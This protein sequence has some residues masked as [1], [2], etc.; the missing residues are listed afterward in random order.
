MATLTRDTEAGHELPS[1]CW[2]FQVD[3]FKK[4]DEKT[5]HNDDEA[6]KR[7]G[8]PAAV[9]VGPQVAALIFRQLLMTFERGWIEGGRCELTFRRPVYM[10]Q[11][12]TARGSVTR[13]ES[14]E[15]GTR[16]H[17]DVWVENEKGEKVIVGN[18][19]GV[20]PASA[21]EATKNG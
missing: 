9:A 3:Q 1:I 16:L 17:C 8:L 20:V 6:A 19:S 5:I 21:N 18:A 7:E 11:L 10:P 2:R 4:G 13:R 14:I 15:G 12:C